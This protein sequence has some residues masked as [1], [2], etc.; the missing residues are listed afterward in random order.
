[1]PREKLRCSFCNK[2]QADVKKLIAG[3]GV[4]I[5]DECVDICL[6]ILAEDG[7]TERGDL[8]P[9][10]QSPASPDSCSRCG[11]ATV[12]LELPRG[13]LICLPCLIAV[14]SPHRSP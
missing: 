5:C 12:P 8:P 11:R 9:A 6:D 14:R 10:A 7:V 4:F 13:E 1:M 2:S 3:P